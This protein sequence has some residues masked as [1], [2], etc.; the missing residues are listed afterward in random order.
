MVE[1]DATGG[2]SSSLGFACSLNPESPYNNKKLLNSDDKLKCY[3]DTNKIIEN[4]DLSPSPPV[5]F[6]DVYTTKIYLRGETTKKEFIL[7]TSDETKNCFPT[8]IDLKEVQNAPD[9][10]YDS[11]QCI[12]WT[13]DNFEFS[14]TI[15]PKMIG[16]IQTYYDV[17]YTIA[18]TN[19]PFQNEN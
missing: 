17:N 3:Y 9:F 10:I 2:V 12:S 7:S 15:T 19:N 8:L 14:W 6:S 5:K 11:F 4:L 16:R 13:N 18:S 1:S